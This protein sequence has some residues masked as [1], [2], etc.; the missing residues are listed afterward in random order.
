MLLVI[1]IS[2][3]HIMNI[4]CIGILEMR[5]RLVLFYSGNGCQSLPSPNVYYLEPKRE[6]MQRGV[7]VCLEKEVIIL[8]H[9]Q[10]HPFPLGFCLQTFS[11]NCVRTVFPDAALKW[12]FVLWG[13]EEDGCWLWNQ[14]QPG[15]AMISRQISQRVKIE[16]DLSGELWS[17]NCMPTFFQVKAIDLGFHSPLQGDRD[18]QTSGVQA[19]GKGAAFVESQM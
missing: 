6:K 14:G 12:R 5:E 16:S 11:P 2:K 8:V 4:D 7:F 3:L 9:L 10:H 13:T 19:V 18:P 1:I 17:V 15:R